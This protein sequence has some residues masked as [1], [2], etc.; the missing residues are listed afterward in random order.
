MPAIA[1]VG[2][3]VLLW[4]RSDE[5]HKNRRDMFCG[6]PMHSAI[7]SSLYAYL[8][9]LNGMA[10][11]VLLA[12]SAHSLVGRLRP[13]FLDVCRPDW[14]Q[15][16]CN[17]DGRQKAVYI[18]NYTCRGDVERFGEDAETVL[19][20]ARKSFFSGH[21]ST[22]FASM[23]FVIL[24]LQARVA[25]KS[26]NGVLLV[27]FL[28]L[29]AFGLA[30]ITAISRVTDCAHHP[31]DVIAG[32]IVGMSVQILNVVY[33]QRLFSEE[34]ICVGDRATPVKKCDDL[35]DG[36]ESIPMLEPKDENAS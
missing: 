8:Y 11:T 12:T 16:G 25:S 32:A 35:P 3:E 28:Q 17:L 36:A 7:V 15:I 1:I 23:T 5:G 4:Y 21:A 9:F 19:E 20:D 34:D 6:L 22:A 33:I 24:Y 18:T 2:T 26:S 27:P 30:F 14:D 10:F 31:S 13:H 29:F